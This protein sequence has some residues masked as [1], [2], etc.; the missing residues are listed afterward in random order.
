MMGQAMMSSERVGVQS[1]IRLVAPL[2]LYT[3]CHSHVLNLSIA[4]VKWFYQ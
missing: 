1:W 2:A 3:H 4:A